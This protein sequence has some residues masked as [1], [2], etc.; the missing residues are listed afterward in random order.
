MSSLKSFED[1]ECWKAARDLRMFVSQNILLKFPIDEKYAL[2][3]QLKR[4]SRSVSDNIAE[5]FGRY[6]YQENI[7]FCRIARG[8]LTE[9]L[10]QVITARDEN[11]IEEDLIQEFR[12]K[13]ERTKAILN[14]YINYL[15]KTKME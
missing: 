5:G 12:E 8:S 7:Q 11:Y 14:G 1:L 3:S 10:N 6:H 13:F 9:S 15:A 4:S 2:T